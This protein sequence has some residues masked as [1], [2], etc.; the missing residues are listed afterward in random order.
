MTHMLPRSPGILY[1]PRPWVQG[2]NE[3]F[4]CVFPVP[5]LLSRNCA[6]HT[7][8]NT[9]QWSLSH[10]TD[11]AG[12]RNGYLTQAGVWNWDPRAPLSA[13]F[14]RRHA[15]WGTLRIRAHSIREIWEGGKDRRTD[16]WMDGKTDLL[17]SVMDWM[18]VSLQ[19]PNLRTLSPN[20][21]VL[22]GG[23]FGR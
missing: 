7:C 2:G 3:C 11:V 17:G 6:L 13:R 20:M 1:L 12:V 5:H 4:C 9:S 19:N 16:G 18:L 22:W 23:V 8:K 14:H 21:M 10:K 15:N